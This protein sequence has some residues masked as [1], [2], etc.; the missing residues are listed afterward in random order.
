MHMHRHTHTKHT[1]TYTHIRTHINTQDNLQLLS[2]P[3]E[4]ETLFDLRVPI[5]LYLE[6]CKSDELYC[7]ATEVRCWSLLIVLLLRCDVDYCWLFLLLMT[8]V[9]DEP[10]SFKIAIV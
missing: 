1:I 8:L 9:I 5:P 7:F 3:I 10:L 4:I 2:R 6:A